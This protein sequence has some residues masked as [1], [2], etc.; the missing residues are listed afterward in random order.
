MYFTYV[1]WPNIPQEGNYKI[2]LVEQITK[3]FWADS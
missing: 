1:T 2:N 3:E